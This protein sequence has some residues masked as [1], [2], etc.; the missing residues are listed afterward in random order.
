MFT[1]TVALRANGVVEIYSD[2]EYVST[3]Y[4]GQKYRPRFIV[5]I[6]SDRQN[7]YLKCLELKTK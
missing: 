1:V 7:F 3:V 5:D 6:E 4:L 2:F